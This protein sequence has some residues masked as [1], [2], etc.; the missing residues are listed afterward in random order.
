MKVW[1][2]KRAKTLI[3]LITK[4]QITVRQALAAATQTR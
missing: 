2:G 1:I 4:V 3:S